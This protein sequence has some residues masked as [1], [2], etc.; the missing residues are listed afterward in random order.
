MA[1]VADV[2][3]SVALMV[4]SE[5]LVPEL[6]TREASPVNVLEGEVIGSVLEL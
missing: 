4:M 6:F 3:E 5:E 1:D 2:A